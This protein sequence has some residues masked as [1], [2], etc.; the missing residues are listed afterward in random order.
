MAA[1]RGERMSAAVRGAPPVLVVGMHR[2]GTS[3]VTRVLERL[4]VFMGA[5]QEGNREST[6]FL[7][8]NEWIL[9]AAGARWD[10]PEPLE[11]VW[12]RPDAVA[13]LERALEERLR[14]RG[15]KGYLGRVRALTRATPAALEEPWGF[16]D[17]RTTLTL[18]L[19]LR[20]LPGARVVHVVRDGVDVAASLRA[21]SRRQLAGLGERPAPD[22]TRAP[23]W[24]P[25]L[26]CLELEEGLALWAWYLDR[27]RENV[28][29]RASDTPL[30]QIRYESLLGEPGEEAGRLAAF[31]GLPA[32]DRDALDPIEGLV[33]AGRASAHRADPELSA[34]AEEHAGVLARHGY[35]PS[36]PPRK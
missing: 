20:L 32:P 1:A 29:V 14:G 5:D 6:F 15:R 3:L 22:G 9:S 11:D 36:G 30:H 24:F 21:R 2:S 26:R 17:P 31:L 8:C 27:C 19:W 4:G 25:S 16:K 28:T 18:P 10:R 12:A 35:G 7:A 23:N 33:D 34:F 13:F